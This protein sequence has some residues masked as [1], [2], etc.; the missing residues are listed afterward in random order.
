MQHP[1]IHHI[2]AIAGNARE[3]VAFYTGLLGLRMVKKTV[4]FDDPG[5]YHLYY[6]DQAGSPGTILTFFPWAG[7]PKGKAG[8]GEVTRIDFRA[9]A[10][11][12]DFWAERLSGVRS[13]LQGANPFGEQVIDFND[14]DGMHLRIVFA[15]GPAGDPWQTADIA[16]SHAITG[17]HAAAMTVAHSDATRAVLTDV[18]GFTLAAEQAGIVRLSAGGESQGMLIDLLPAS[19]VAR[20]VQGAGTVHHIAFRAGND[21]EQAQM[22]VA[23]REQ[24]GIPPTEQKDRNYFRSIYFREPSGVLFEIATDDPGFA[25]DE[26]LA[27]LGEALKLPSQYEQ[28]R[29]KIEAVLPS[30]T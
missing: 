8:P 20:G 28:Y 29:G 14:P 22:A 25:V 27:T 6:G 11:A 24:F 12:H 4:N 1:G 7:V 23:L 15:E 17:F 9:P 10:G 30:L 19:G 26:P 18:A 16:T 3:N 2:T 5:T 21:A 13:H